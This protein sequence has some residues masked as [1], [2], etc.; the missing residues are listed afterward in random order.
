MGI[1][2]M[3]ATE[4]VLLNFLQY[5][6]VGV[7]GV[8]MSAVAQAV[9]FAGGR[10]TGS[11]RYYDQGSLLPVLSQLEKCGVGLYAQDGS[12]VR[13]GADVVVVSTAIEDDNP[14]LVVA[15][16]LGLP[17][18][19]RS[20]VLAELVAGKTCVAVAG[21]SGKSTVT[22]MVGWILEQA[23]LDPFVVNG[24]PVIN[25]QSEDC[26]GNARSGRTSNIEH[27]TSNIESN[28]ALS[29]KSPLL[30]VGR[31][32]E[33]WV[34]EADESDRSLLNF[35]PEYAVVTNMSAD[36]FGLEDT[37]ALFEEFKSKVRG[38]IVGAL[39]GSGYLDGVDA[40]VTAS[41][42]SF[43][44]DGVEFELPLAGRHN[45]EDALHATVLCELVGVS[46]GQSAVAL[47][48]FRGIHRR[49]EVVGKADGVTVIDDYGHNPAKIAAAWNAVVPFARRGIVVWRPHG[50]GPLRSLLD[51]LNDTFSHLCRGDDL[52]LLLP[53]YDAGGTANRT[54]GSEVLA[55]MLRL[56]GV[57]VRCVKSHDEVVDVVEHEAQHGDAVIV[58]GAR[59]PKL[60]ELARRI[61]GRLSHG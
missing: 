53:V 22:G 18:L 9:G 34:I 25:W 21:T 48:S 13:D 43:V 29:T 7:A 28:A 15:R 41:S 6:F 24:A 37:V 23:G 60:P 57:Q 5:H 16:E 51:E 39:D 49:L 20:E 14:D 10:V 58:M 61:L 31:S 38:K 55:E 36:H 17:V 2:R 19:H 32:S 44:Y 26:I 52:L 4:D 30:D 50:F 56:R 1:L 54:I 40:D 59:D 47:R 45:V 27:S 3:N 46:V 8:G 42:S 11:D 33:L 35:S 12:G